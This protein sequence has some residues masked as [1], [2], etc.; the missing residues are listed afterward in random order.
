MVLLNT[1]NIAANTCLYPA[2]RSLNAANTSKLA[3]PKTVVILNPF[4]RYPVSPLAPYKAN[5][6]NCETQLKLIITNANEDGRNPPETRTVSKS[7]QF[8]RFNPGPVRIR[9][10]RERERERERDV[11]EKEHKISFLCSFRERERIQKSI[12][13]R[14]ADAFLRVL[15]EINQFNATTKPKR[16]TGTEQIPLSNS[17]LQTFL[18]VFYVQG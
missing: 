18:A 15:K 4:F 3:P 14:A 6:S 7:S 13:T 9:F 2:C 16:L 10:Q 1:A 5:T 12:Q 17:T 11:S 8:S